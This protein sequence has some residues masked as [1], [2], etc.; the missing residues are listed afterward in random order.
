MDAR[1]AHASAR[2]ADRISAIVLLVA[3]LFVIVEARTLPYWQGNAPGPGF[4]PLWL[5]VLLAC[6]AAGLMARTFRHAAAGLADAAG[7]LPDRP[8]A[9][10]LAVVVGLVAAAAGLALAVGLVAATAAFVGATLAYLRPGHRRA[11]LLAALLTPLIVWLLF[12]KWLAVPLPAGPL[13]F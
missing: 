10:R 9:V 13:G 7:V 6:A 4:M 5:G 2:T 3:A 11:N 1:P 8:A 12:V